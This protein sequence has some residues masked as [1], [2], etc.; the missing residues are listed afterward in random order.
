MRRRYVLGI[1]PGLQG[2]MVGIDLDTGQPFEASWADG[3]DGY[4][5]RHRKVL[6]AAY[7]AELARWARTWGP[8]ELVVVE[9]V[10][11]RAHQGLAP[12]AR[13]AY[14][15][16]IV[17]GTVS[18]LGWPRESPTPT[19][20]HR[21]LSMPASPQDPKAPVIAWCARRFPQLDLFPGARRKRPHDGIAD[22]AAIAWFGVLRARELVAAG[23]EEI[24]PAV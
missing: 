20:W 24:A 16:G 4:I 6:E 12:Q 15:I 19:H 3:E 21:V 10:Q 18:A 11:L 22:A 9:A 7:P 2:A 23:E 5:D 17:V 14:G 13:A 8:P 1:D